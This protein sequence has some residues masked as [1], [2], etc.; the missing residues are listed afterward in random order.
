MNKKSKIIAASVLSITLVSGV[1]IM[2]N[3]TQQTV[4]MLK[5]EEV[6]IQDIDINT[7]TNG[8]HRVDIPFDKVEGVLKVENGFAF[9]LIKDNQDSYYILAAGKINGIDHVEYSKYLGEKNSSENQKVDEQ[10]AVVFTNDNARKAY[11]DATK[12]SIIIENISNGTTTQLKEYF[13][14]TTITDFNNKVKFAYH[15]GYV[16]LESAKGISIIGTDSGKAYLKE[17][18]G[19]K[20]TLWADNNLRFSYIYL[21]DESR[22]RIGIY[23]VKTKNYAFSPKLSTYHIEEI[24][25]WVDN[26]R[27]LL[28]SKDKNTNKKEILLY[29]LD[30]N[31]YKFYN[32]SK[33]FDGYSYKDGLLEIQL[34]NEDKSLSI[35]T[36]NFNTGDKKYYD[37]LSKMTIVENAI[38]KE[39]VIHEFSTGQMLFEKDSVLY[40]KSEDK[41]RA[42]V[43]MEEKN[44]NINVYD[45]RYI[46][47][48]SNNS[49]IIYDLKEM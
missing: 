27:L 38:A 14:E 35:R 9:K 10:K 22:N 16:S 47:V 6:A 17:N 2:F 45:D 42:I 3:R 46:F 23:N 20:S 11:Y 7:D 12:N 8:I 39:C 41:R 13:D 19:G 26:N 33:G 24:I 37:N 30:N 34:I 43:T 1:Y 40:L 21:Q 31:K 5:P 44:K 25:S 29:D 32:N 48:A 28:V 49:I 4:R 36:I 18:F 15:G